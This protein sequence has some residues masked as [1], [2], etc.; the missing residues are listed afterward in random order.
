MRWD[1]TYLNNLSW[2]TI[3]CVY[4][5]LFALCFGVINCA[6]HR[7][8]IQSRIESVLKFLILFRRNIEQSKQFIL[9]VTCS[10][11][12]SFRGQFWRFCNTFEHF[13]WLHVIC[14]YLEAFWDCRVN[15]STLWNGFDIFFDL[16]FCGKPLRRSCCDWE[17]HARMWNF[18]LIH[19]FVENFNLS[20]WWFTLFKISSFQFPSFALI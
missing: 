11:W 20:G 19:I 8:Y 14:C 16:P 10:N 2:H 15:S 1:S 5:V 17:F 3:I 18:N 4:C 7:D 12:A 13:Y 9:S 6:H